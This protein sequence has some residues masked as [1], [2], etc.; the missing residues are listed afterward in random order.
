MFSVTTENASSTTVSVKWTCL[1]RT[2]DGAW[3][4]LSASGPP[5]IV[6]DPTVRYVVVSGTAH[7]IDSTSVWS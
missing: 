1:G 4:V 2:S 6:V 7:V 5:L 3:L